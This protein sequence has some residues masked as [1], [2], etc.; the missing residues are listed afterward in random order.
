MLYPLSYEGGGGGIVA[1]S[2][3]IEVIARQ[4]ELVG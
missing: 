3:R 2:A 4:S 1:C